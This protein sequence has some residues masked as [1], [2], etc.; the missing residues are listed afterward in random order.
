MGNGF[1]TDSGILPCYLAGIVY[2]DIEITFPYKIILNFF[3]KKKNNCIL[4]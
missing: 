2:V 1:K 4:K 3:F